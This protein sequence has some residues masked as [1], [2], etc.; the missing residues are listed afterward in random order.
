MADDDSTT[1]DPAVETD[2]A[3]GQQDDDNLGDPGKRALSEERRQRRIAEKA[4]NEAMAR[5]KDYEDRDKTDQQKL[6]ERASTA[7]KVAADA[8]RELNRLMAARAAGLDLEDA[9]LITGGSAEEM[10]A[11]AERLAERFG[12]KV[13]SFDGGTRKPANAPVDMNALIRRDRVK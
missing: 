5:L 10:K 6:E 9:D 11:S 8:T 12:Q 1:T 7:E 13:P 4:H 3:A 2:P